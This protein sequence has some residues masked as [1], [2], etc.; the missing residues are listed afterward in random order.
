MQMLL[1]GNRSYF[2]D[3]DIIHPYH[4]PPFYVEFSSKSL[5]NER[6]LSLK[7]RKEYLP[8]LDPKKVDR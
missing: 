1:M 4:V 2:K 5:M 6:L 8:S 3:K 7:Q